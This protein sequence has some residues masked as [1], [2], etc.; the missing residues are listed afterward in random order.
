MTSAA[1]RALDRGLGFL[2]LGAAF[3]CPWVGATASKGI[4]A[5]LGL[6]GYRYGVRL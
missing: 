5:L 2:T 4:D 1:R 3:A 6:A